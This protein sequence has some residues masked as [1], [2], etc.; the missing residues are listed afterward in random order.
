V[1]G[2]SQHVIQRGNNRTDIFRSDFDREVFLLMMREASERHGTDIHGYCLMTNHVHVLATPQTPT[3]LEKTMHLVEGRYAGFF[4]K[5]YGRT[6]SPFDGR[7]RPTVIGDERSWYACLRYIELNPVR[8]GIVSNPG[9]YVWSSYHFNAFG[10][11]D[12]LLTPH[13]FYLRLGLSVKDRQ[14]CWAKMCDAGLSTEELD[15]LRFAVHEARILGAIR[16]P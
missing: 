14:T 7:Y 3:S 4:N 2:V 10:T 6:G 16:I 12:P 1:A 8:A 11:P 5:R 9:E 13:E 15:Q